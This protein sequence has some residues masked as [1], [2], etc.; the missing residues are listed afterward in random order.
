MKV[1]VDIY[2]WSKGWQTLCTLKSLMLHSGQHIDK[3]Y[4][5][6][7]LNPVSP[8]DIEWITPY[9][10]N[11]IINNSKRINRIS[12]DNVGWDY[13]N[14]DNR[15][16]L[17]GQYCLEKSDKKYVYFTHTDVLY[18][19][20]VIGDMLNKINDT[21]GI[22]IVGICWVC[23]FGRAGLCHGSKFGEY[24][25]TYNQALEVSK[26]TPPLRNAEIDIFQVIPAPECRLNEWACLIDREKTLQAG[27]PYFG[28]NGNTESG[29]RWFRNMILKGNKFV[30][31]TGNLYEHG[32]WANSCGM[33]AGIGHP[34]QYAKAEFIAKQYFHE[35]FN[36]K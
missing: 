31:Y 33:D 28:I 24:N 20:D 29:C 8:V 25:P 16:S 1:D 30:H 36:D 11:I 19:G 9:F 27:F 12:E 15:H 35:H 3:I 17:L 10:D 23:H 7:P 34:I 4:L 5:T 18:T 13:S 26:T 32:Y 21:A 22:G 6:I 2:S 14:E